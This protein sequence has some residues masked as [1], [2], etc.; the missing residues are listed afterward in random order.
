ME[1]KKPGIEQFLEA[2]EISFQP[3]VQNLHAYL[4]ENGCIVNVEEKKSGFFASYKYGKRKKSIINLLFRKAGLMARIYGENANKYPEFLNTLPE[5]MFQSI[6]EARACK[7]LIDPN[8]CSPTCS[9]GY[10]FTV[11]GK[12]FQI[13]RY[14]G[15]EFF[16]TN[17][18]SPCIK[19]F[20]ENEMKERA[21]VSV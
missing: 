5:E 3:F 2:V 15:F 13:C 7:R 1:K 6:E 20:I 10:D 17:E 8:A 14:G 12:R 4:T 9:K 19:L 18:N 21:T 16:I 11:G